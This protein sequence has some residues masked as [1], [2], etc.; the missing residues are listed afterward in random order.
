MCGSSVQRSQQPIA[1]KITI[2]PLSCAGQLKICLSSTDERVERTWHISHLTTILDVRQVLSDESC[3][4]NLKHLH[5]ITVWTSD[6]QEVTRELRR[7]R[8]ISHF[9]TVLA[10]DQREVTKSRLGD[11]QNSHFTIGFS[12]GVQS[13]VAAHSYQRLLSSSCQQLFLPA[14]LIASLWS[15]VGRQLLSHHV[16]VVRS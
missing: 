5:F 2:L 13:Y 8:E 6:E 7:R 16:A 12:V 15:E 9:T 1:H 10:S 4:G 14:I 3:V 11:V